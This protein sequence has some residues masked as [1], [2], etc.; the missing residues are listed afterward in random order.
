MRYPRAKPVF[1]TK[2]GKLYVGL[3]EDLLAG[4]LGKRLRGK[5]QL[6]FTSPPFPLNQKKEYGNRSGEEYANWLK[7]LAPAFG[8]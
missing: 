2:L 8:C 4:E 3:A 7:S 6:L 5:V 1:R